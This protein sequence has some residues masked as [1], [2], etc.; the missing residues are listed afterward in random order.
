MLRHGGF[1][2][3]WSKFVSKAKLNKIFL[4]TLRGFLNWWRLASLGR[5]EAR[6]CKGDV[7][8]A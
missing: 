1:L 4:K 2:N 8:R 3:E 6:V 7:K 5:G